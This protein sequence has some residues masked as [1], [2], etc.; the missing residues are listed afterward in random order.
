[1]NVVRSLVA[2][3]IFFWPF[4]FGLSSATAVALY[5]IVLLVVLVD[6]N[7]V[8]HLHAHRPFSSNRVA[9]IVLDLCLGS[10]TGMTSA[11]WRIQHVYG[12]HRGMTRTTRKARWLGRYGATVSLALICTRLATAFP[13]SGSPS[14]N[15]IGRESCRI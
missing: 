5:A 14:S 3:L 9:N 8:L 15:P 12:H 2:P 6:L 13:R 1:M 10:V 7:Y 4:L 11:N